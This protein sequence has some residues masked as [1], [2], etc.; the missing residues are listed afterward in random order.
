MM[1]REEILE[2]TKDIVSFGVKDEDVDAYLKYIR[3]LPVG[4]IVVEF[5]TG[6]S[7]NVTRIALSNPEVDVFTFDNAEESMN[8]GEVM[9]FKEISR[10]L[11][12]ARVDNVYFT[13]G[14]SRTV[15]KEWNYP[16]DVLNVDSSHWYEP[17]MA[18]FKR[19]EPFVKPGGYILLH[20]YHVQDIRVEGLQKA[21]D[22]YFRNERFE[23]IEN[24]GQTQVVL[25]KA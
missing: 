12:K 23:F 22:E 8:L 18:E 14:D 7:K 9:Y 13:L 1:T 24:L 20:D 10:C 16:I 11:R 17:S 6:R 15:F 19:W 3:P 4:S 25:K 2:V 21:V 5:G